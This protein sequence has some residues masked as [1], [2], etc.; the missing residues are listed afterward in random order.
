[1]KITKTKLNDNKEFVL[2]CFKD[3][4]EKK[5]D[6]CRKC[7]DFIGPMNAY[8][9]SIN[10]LTFPEII[11]YETNEEKTNIKS[12]NEDKIVTDKIIVEEKVI[13][14]KTVNIFRDGNRY[15]SFVG[16]PNESNMTESICGFGI[17]ISD[18]LINLANNLKK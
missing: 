7:D 1:M 16:D 15:C 17:T 13:I 12:N 3:N 6:D 2:I 10:V 9:H 18:S 5:L 4:K 14:I 8:F 11:C